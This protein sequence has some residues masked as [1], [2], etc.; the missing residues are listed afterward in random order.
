MIKINLLTERKPTRAR[1]TS[2]LK[3]EGARSGGG[4]LLG[5]IFMIGVVIAGGWWWM[6]A[7]ETA[8]WEQKLSEA[9]TELARLAPAIEKSNEFEAQKKLLS[10][11]IALI[12]DLKAR[13]EVPMHIM[14]QL[15]RNLPE[16]LWMESMTANNNKIVIGGKATT[17]NAVSNFYGNLNESGHFT[18]V[19]LGRTFEVPEGVSFSLTCRFGGVRS[20]PTEAEQG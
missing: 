17:Y 7:R 2:S 10:R 18:D 16:F 3:L 12:T 1:A 4:I 14:D 19:T 9:D 20:E 6:V 15:S 11:K 5:G 8:D 13:Q